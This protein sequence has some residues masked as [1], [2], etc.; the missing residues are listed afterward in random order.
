MSEAVDRI[1]RTITIVTAIIAATVSA[2]TLLSTC[3]KQAFD[4]YTSF[5]GAVETEERF[6]KGLYDDY[7]TTFG[8]D[9]TDNPIHRGQ[10]LIAIHTIA[11]RDV[12][13]FPEFDVPPTEKA[14]A[15][16]RLDRMKST[17]LNSLEDR[18]SGDP[19]LARRLQQRSF[20][21]QLTSR[22]VVAPR[23]QPAPTPS[24]TGSGSGA[25][26]PAA[27]IRQL[28]P[29]S[30]T[31]WDI[32]VFWCEGPFA[33]AN[34]R[35]ADALANAF[36]SFAQSERTIAPGVKL[37]RVRVRPASPGF[38][39][40]PGSPAVRS[41]VV[42]DTGP[43]EAEAG[44]AVG[45]LVNGAIGATAPRFALRRSGG[46]PTPWYISVFACSGPAGTAPRSA[47][48]PRNVMRR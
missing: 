38:Q 7:L 12:A 48:V 18:Q 30:D 42:Y 33:E 17:L 40:L 39:Q 15:V 36:A 23:G 21:A 16:A 26:R 6:W 2:N 41:S 45:R 27:G 44:A 14:A 37:G 9:F 31:G 29:V 43:G 13:Q 10:K 11:Q 5:R 32:D 25:G 20:D 35:T 24:A 8:K 22:A 47:A 3:T 28:T 4:R 34:Q 46:K 1:G 19:L